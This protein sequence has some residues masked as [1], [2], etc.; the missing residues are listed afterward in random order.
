MV[1]L[2]NVVV[3]VK[4]YNEY[5]VKIRV[6]IIFFLFIIRCDFIVFIGLY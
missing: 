3:F 1:V 4:V 6:K 2:F 5:L